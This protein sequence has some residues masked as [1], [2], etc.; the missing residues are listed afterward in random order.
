M[1]HL[2]QDAIEVFKGKID[3]DESYFGG[4]RKRKCGRGAAEKIAVF[5][6]LKRDG[7]VYVKIVQDTKTISRY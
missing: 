3:L 5:G 7:K 2:N 4:V 6:M 1:Y